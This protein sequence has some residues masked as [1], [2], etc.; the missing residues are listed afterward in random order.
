[1]KLKWIKLNGAEPIPTQ[2]WTEFGWTE[3]NWTEVLHRSETVLWLLPVSISSSPG[4][5][6]PRTGL[7]LQNLSGPKLDLSLRQTGSV[8]LRLNV[9]NKP[10]RTQSQN[11]VELP[12]SE[13]QWVQLELRM[14]DE[15]K[16]R[17]RKSLWY[18]VCC[19]WSADSA[20][21]VQRLVCHEQ[22]QLNICCASEPPSGPMGP[23]YSGDDLLLLGRHGNAGRSGP[24][25]WN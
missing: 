14:S 10:I 24:S 19:R 2:N 1:M 22:Q 21:S 4:Q 9:Q 16:R 18:Q 15:R 12:G 7:P 13:N 11:P 5:N 8:P 20:E 23:T 25:Q 6:Q 17:K 3:Q